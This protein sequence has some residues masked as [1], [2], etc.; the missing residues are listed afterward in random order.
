VFG[1]LCCFVAV[2]VGFCLVGFILW[3][4]VL[5]LGNVAVGV[6]FALIV[7]LGISR[8]VFVLFVGVAG[9]WCLWVCYSLLCGV[10]LFGVLVFAL[11]FWDVSTNLRLFG[12][13]VVVELFVLGFWV[14]YLFVVML[15][16]G[17]CFCSADV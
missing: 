16:F 14:W 8:F 13:C 10:F 15:V 9:C 6:V 2:G 11:T 7:L 12:C 1:V 3:V 5:L 17:W 4:S